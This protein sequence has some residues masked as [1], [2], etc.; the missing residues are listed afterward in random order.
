VPAQRPG[1]GHPIGNSRQAA[2]FKAPALSGR[3][4]DFPADF[5][6]RLVLLDFWATWCLPCRAQMPHL[7]RAYEQYRDRGF[8][9]VGIT[10]DGPQGIPAATVER[11]VRNEKMPWPQVYS[12]AAEIAQSYGVS[13]I[14]AAFLVNGDTGA[15]LA[16]G[17][18]LRGPA[19]IETIEA[20]LKAQDR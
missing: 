6:G 5:K 19:L 7:I 17:D 3:T 14:P 2:A 20:R 4:I 8:Q 1:S 18:E 10:L 9:I 13:A 12:N 16:S 11:F 15:I